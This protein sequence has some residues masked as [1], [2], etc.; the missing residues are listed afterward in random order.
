MLKRRRRRDAEHSRSWGSALHPAFL[1]GSQDGSSKSK[2]VG[3]GSLA[4]LC[5]YRKSSS[6]RLAGLDLAGDPVPL[7][8]QNALDVSARHV[9]P[10]IMG[11][12]DRS[13][14]RLMATY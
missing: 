1:D 10:V 9:L 5:G 13:E 11:E 4:K 7:G 2:Y 3:G 12:W 6:I 14:S 8:A